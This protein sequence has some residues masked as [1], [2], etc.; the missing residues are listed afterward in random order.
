MSITKALFF[1][2]LYTGVE[3]YWVWFIANELFNLN[4]GWILLTGQGVLVGAFAS[5]RD[6]WY[7]K[8]LWHI[9]QETLNYTQGTNKT[10][11]RW[12]GSCIQNI[13]ESIFIFVLEL[14]VVCL[15]G[16]VDEWEDL[17]EFAREYRREILQTI[18]AML[19]FG[20]GFNEV[21]E[22]RPT[23]GYFL[24]LLSTVPGLPALRLLFRC[25]REHAERT[26]EWH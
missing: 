24:M 5:L 6:M 11:L 14:F 23:I 2:A 17:R 8:T 20:F 21:L 15:D 3:T 9:D 26:M 10:F 4:I 22:S 18:M 19:I 7:R 13:G 1:F 25:W 16:L 12:L